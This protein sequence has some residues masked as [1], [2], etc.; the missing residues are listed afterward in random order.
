MTPEE[1]TAHLD[2]ICELI[3]IAIDTLVDRKDSRATVARTALRLAKSETAVLKD[4][5]LLA[6][7][8]RAQTTPT[9]PLVPGNR[10]K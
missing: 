2:R 7:A 9:P 8:L 6:E 4:E 3:Q 5:V 10:K 1:A